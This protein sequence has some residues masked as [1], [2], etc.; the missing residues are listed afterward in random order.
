MNWTAVQ[1][2]IHTFA[3]AHNAYVSETEWNE[4]LIYE[5][6]KIAFQRAKL[7][8]F[9]CAIASIETNKSEIGRVPIETMNIIKVDLLASTVKVC[10]VHNARRLYFNPTMF[11][12]TFE[13][14]LKTAWG[15]T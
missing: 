4:T 3:I 12:D 1:I 9:P 14:N 11:L 6:D 10:V 15:Y 8:V 5:Q 2:A 7:S 13:Q